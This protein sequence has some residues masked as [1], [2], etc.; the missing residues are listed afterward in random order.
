MSNTD[1]LQPAWFAVHVRSRHE[2][3]VADRLEM[4]DIEVFLPK[5]ERV[6][7]WKDR[8]KIVAFPLFPGYLFVHTTRES[9]NLL[10]VLKVVGVVRI[11]CTIPG[12]PD[13][14]PDDQI[15]SLI[16]LVENKEALDPYPYLSEGQRVRITKRTSPGGGRHPR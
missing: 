3:K 4:K 1:K 16:K 5:V 15:M 9:R 2:F 12:Q 11:I 13:P 10:N 8:K 14:I 6:S 7:K